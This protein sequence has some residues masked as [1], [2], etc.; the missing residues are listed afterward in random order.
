MQGMFDG[1]FFHF[2]Q[3]FRIDFCNE[4]LHKNLL[5]ISLIIKSQ[6]E[7]VNFPFFVRQIEKIIKI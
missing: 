1:K 5:K 4:I 7:F 2:Y 6:N 3:N